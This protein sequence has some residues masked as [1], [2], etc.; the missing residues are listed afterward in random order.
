MPVRLRTTISAIEHSIDIPNI[1]AGSQALIGNRFR[2]F[3]VN[4][5]W[6]DN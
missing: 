6:R 3:I 1:H 2:V 5:P 4:G